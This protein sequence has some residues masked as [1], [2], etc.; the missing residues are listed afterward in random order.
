MA[1]VFVL[2]AQGSYLVGYRSADCRTT[3]FYIWKFLKSCIIRKFKRKMY[4]FKKTRLRY[5]IVSEIVLAWQSPHL[6]PPT[7]DPL[8]LH[9]P[10]F[11][12]PFE[13]VLHKRAIFLSGCC[14]SEMRRH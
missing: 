10:L 13:G 11:F 12:L 6:G 5:G 7:V 9:K 8:R 2:V 14:R 4:Y 3:E 1:V